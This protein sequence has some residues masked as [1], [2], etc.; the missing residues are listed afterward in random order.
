[1]VLRHL[2][3]VAAVVLQ[4]VGV[5]CP[6]DD[7]VAFRSELRGE[8]GRTLAAP[9]RLSSK[10]TASAQLSVFW[11]TPSATSRSLPAVI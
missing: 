11:T 7:G 1:V 6:T 10:T 5:G 4:P 8:F 9:D 3:R 2:H